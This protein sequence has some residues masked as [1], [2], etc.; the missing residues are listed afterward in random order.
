MRWLRFA[1]LVCLASVLQ[2]GFLS[3]LSIKLDLMLILVVF[4]ATHI[5]TSEAMITSFILGFA[6]D[7]SGFGQ[8]MGP[9][10]LSFGLVGTAIAFLHRI[11]AIKNKF[12]QAVAIFFV[13]V[14]AG[15]LTGLLNYIK[16]QPVP[17][18]LYKSV[19][20]TALFSGLIGPF[21]FI[22]VAWWMRIGIN[23]YRKR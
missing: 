4:F 19:L 9:Q 14:L 11:I 21:L 3:N 20:Y 16:H 13:T 23:R 1:L 10:M 6:A 5:S 15:F 22:P 12:Y 7:L 2:A 18:H 17:Q 8:T